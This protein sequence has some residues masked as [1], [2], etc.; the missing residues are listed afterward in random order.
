[1]S[2]N[3]GPTNQVPVARLSRELPEEPCLNR[4]LMVAAN[5]AAKQQ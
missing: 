2:F 3:P 1:M 5:Q 4:A